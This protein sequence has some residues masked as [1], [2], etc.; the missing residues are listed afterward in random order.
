MS[1]IGDD[2]GNTDDDDDDDNYAIGHDN[3]DVAADNVVWM[4]IPHAADEHV[5]S[6]LVFL[7]DFSANRIL[8]FGT[9]L[10]IYPQRFH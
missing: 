7:K 1:V 8:I 2:V 5:L 9:I 4:F 10:L 6:S 3:G